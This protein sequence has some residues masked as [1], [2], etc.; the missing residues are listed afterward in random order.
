MSAL[1][2]ALTDPNRAPSYGAIVRGG[3]YFFKSIPIARAVLL[4]DP[5]WRPSSA[6]IFDT[7]APARASLASRWI[8]CSAHCF[9]F[10]VFMVRRQ[11]ETSLNQ[12][13]WLPT[14]W[15]I[16]GWTACA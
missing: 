4:T 10:G 5:A 15:E 2:V 3:G 7:P 8:S 6:A 13:A 12:C 16:Y 1:R 9:G 11:S 14:A